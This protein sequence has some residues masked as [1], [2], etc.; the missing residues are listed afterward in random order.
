MKTIFRACVLWLLSCSAHAGD[1]GGTIYWMSDPQGSSWGAP[2]VSAYYNNCW[3]SVGSERI[4][5]SICPNMGAGGWTSPYPMG[6][7]IRI[8]SCQATMI[9]SDP[10]AY[11]Y[12]VIGSGGTPYDVFC[13]GGGNGTSH[14]DHPLLSGLIQGGGMTGS[15]TPARWIDI[16]TSVNKGTQQMIVVI[17]YEDAGIAQ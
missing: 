10:T 11:G 9:L 6:H 8:K 13:S 7:L 14:T 16:Y 5:L 12:F 2:L 1:L 17:E 3:S 4:R 15:G